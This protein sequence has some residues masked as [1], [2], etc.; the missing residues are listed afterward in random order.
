MT[1]RDEILRRLDEELLVSR[2]QDYGPNGLQV[3]GRPEVTRVVTGVTASVRL[4]EEAIARRADL[5]LVHHGIFWGGPGVV[6]GGHRERLRLLLANDITLA[7]YHLP[8]DGHPTLGNGA[9][10]ARALGLTDI[11][12]FWPYKGMPVGVSGRLQPAED[13]AAFRRRLDAEFPERREFPGGPER[14]SRIAVVTG[15]GHQALAEA[16]WSGFDALITGEASEPAMHVAAEEG[17]HFFGAGH[18][19]TEVYGVRALA[20]W[21]PEHFDV[22][23]EFVDIPN[24]V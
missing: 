2:F 11:E 15:G 1:S 20:E 3:E 7:A 22:E 6:R 24:P 12:P 19:A 5:L 16:A 14:L 13:L 23:A 4:I 18:H 17:I 8:L 10:L 21:L 9:Q